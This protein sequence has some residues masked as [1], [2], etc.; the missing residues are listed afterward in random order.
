ML[1]W[2]SQAKNCNEL[3]NCRI[4][5]VSDAPTLH[6]Y[7][8]LKCYTDLLVCTVCIVTRCHRSVIPQCEVE[9]LRSCRSYAG[10]CT[11]ISSDEKS[12]PGPPLQ[13]EI[14]LRA[15]QYKNPRTCATN[16]RVRSFF[17]LILF[18]G[19]HL[20]QY[21]TL[22][23]ECNVCGGITATYDHKFINMHNHAKLH[24]YQYHRQDKRQA[25]SQVEHARSC[26]V[27]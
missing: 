27:L 8:S 14:A 5:Q 16:M 13:I 15:T 17:G 3:C 25:I 2:P 7:A 23:S 11:L 1:H 4:A 19:C 21:Q 20:P 9:D 22:T 24:T 10:V 12:I 26:K 6:G 18:W